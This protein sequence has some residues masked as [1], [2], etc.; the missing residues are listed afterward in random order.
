MV[1]QKF[2]KLTGPQTTVLS[3]L[4]TAVPVL[5]TDTLPFVQGG[6]TKKVGIDDL[7]GQIAGT[8]ATT[9]L[10]NTAGVMTVAAKLIHLVDNEKSSLFV[11][12]G[13]FNFSGSASAVDTKII[14]SMAAKGQLL[15]ALIS[16][17]QVAN[18]TTS[19][20]LSISKAA[21]AATKMTGDLTI[22]LS[23]TVYLNHVNNCLVMWP[24]SGADSI[25]AAEG[26]V[27][28]YAAASVGRS[29]GK[30]KYMLVFMKTA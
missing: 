8:A 28:M 5:N 6:V 11:E 18:G 2:S 26:D 25:V 20:V 15:C 9:G 24:V 23:D 27:Y 16:V 14:D 21:V 17:S 22:T 1:N 29:A 4:D 7:V 3:T 10:D 13:E 19:A 30:V 12:T